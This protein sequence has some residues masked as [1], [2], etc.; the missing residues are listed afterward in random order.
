M[1]LQSDH[2]QFK[3]IYASILYALSA[4]KMMR[5]RITEGSADCSIA[6]VRIWQ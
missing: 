6:Y 5:V 2:P 3:T 1:V 4:G